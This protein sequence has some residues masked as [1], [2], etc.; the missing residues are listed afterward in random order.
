M[1]G[2]LARL[3]YLGNG[4]IHVITP[5]FK[6]R[7]AKSTYNLA[8][9]SFPN[10]RSIRLPGYD[11]TQPGGYFV[12]L[13]ANNRV[14]I[15]GEI[16]D[17]SV[18][19]SALGVVLEQEWLYLPHRF[20]HLELDAYVIMPNHFHGIILLNEYKGDQ[21]QDRAEK[22]EDF[23]KPVAGSIPTIIRS[24]KSS[25]TQKARLLRGFPSQMTV[26]QRN[27]Y[28]HVIRTPG[29]LDQIRTYILGNPALWE[30]DEHHYH[31]PE[32]KPGR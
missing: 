26:W 29:A 1:C 24:F 30:Q 10:R 3:H 22:K 21:S 8:M 12:T 14:P 6:S 32:K 13:L 7:N 18:H 17:Y 2:G 23:G 27:Y 19:L 4:S 15:F 20:G 28:E 25:V 16:M 5:F 9:S 11:Y 31:P